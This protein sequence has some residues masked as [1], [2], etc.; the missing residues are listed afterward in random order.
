MRTAQNQS[1][2]LPFLMDVTPTTRMEESNVN[3]IFEYNYYSQ[4][5]YCMGGQTVGTKSF[6]VETTIKN[7][8]GHYSDKKNKVDDTKRK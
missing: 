8:G 4:M 7:G 3:T 5:A 1:N 2:V 6:T